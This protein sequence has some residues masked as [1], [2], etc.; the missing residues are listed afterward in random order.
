MWG[1]IETEIERCL[2]RGVKVL[3]ILKLEEYQKIEEKTWGTYFGP[4][5]GMGLDVKIVPSLHTKLYMNEQ[6]SL[7]TSMNL[8]DYSMKNNEELGLLTDDE[9]ITKQLNEYVKDLKTRS[10]EM[11][12]VEINYE[13]E[14]FPEFGVCIRCCNKIPFEIE[15]PLCK[16]CFTI[17]NEYK[18]RTYPEKYCHH[19]KKDDYGTITF[20]KPICV[21]CRTYIF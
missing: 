3:L 6:M 5:E 20:N 2:Q 8:Y 12:D 4:Y 10:I 19:C 14:E 11:K 15:K 18:N 9:E 17:W 7:I 21:D 1:H 13:D 16:D